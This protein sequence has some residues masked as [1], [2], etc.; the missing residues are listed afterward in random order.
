MY[1]RIACIGGASLDRKVVPLGKLRAGT[2]N[3]VESASCPGGTARNIA[4]ALARLGCSA[5]LFT[6]VGRD[7]TGEQIF[8]QLR[9]L[10]VDLDG[11]DRA[12]SSPTASYTAL[13]D[14]ASELVYGL[15]DMEILERLDVGWLDPIAEGLAA[16]DL[17][18]LDA[19]LPVAVLERLAALA[20]E[21]VRIYA[22]PVSVE[23]S[24]RLASILDRIDTLFPDRLE[25]AALSGAEGARDAAADP[26]RLAAAIRERGSRRVLITLGEDG[27]WVDDPPRHE[28]VP[29]VEA[30]TVI[31]VTGAG[32]CFLAGYVFAQAAGAAIDPVRC[33]LIAATFAVESPRSVPAE[34]TAERLLARYRSR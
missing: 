33:G 11:V 15:A 8:A 28:R 7:A 16:H 22:D 32:D 10:G 31:D 19:N 24:G 34:L 20:P 27:V 14:E 26:A 2:S 12:E 3:P 6:R 17:W 30:S 5:S 18:I 25:A 29:A 9:R 1:E 13:L 21:G 23:K 4:E